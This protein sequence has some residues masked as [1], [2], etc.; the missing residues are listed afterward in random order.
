MTVAAVTRPAVRGT[1]GP[2]VGALLVE[3][4]DELVAA[5]RRYMAQA[6]LTPLID[7][8]QDR[9]PSLPAAPRT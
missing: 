6:T 9:L 3:V 8:P 7:H 2:L 4:N 5:P 1:L